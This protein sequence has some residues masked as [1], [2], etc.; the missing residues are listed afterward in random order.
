VGRRR[1]GRGQPRPGHHQV[2]RLRAAGLPRRRRRR[3]GRAQ[4]RP[5]GRQRSSALPRLVRDTDAKIGAIT[6][7]PGSAQS[8]ADA[9]V[10]AGITSIL[11]F[12]PIVL[13]TPDSV[14]V[15]NVDLCVELQILSFYEQ[16]R[17]EPVGGA[18][19]G[20]GAKLAPNTLKVVPAS[21]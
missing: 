21:V 12:A 14:S 19:G 15:R 1:R 6:T 20:A 2:H 16:M 3:R 8:A 7:P 10:S 11:N 5:E 17:L 18:A 13:T 4:D 9:L